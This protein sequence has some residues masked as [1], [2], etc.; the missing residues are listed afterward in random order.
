[1][2]GVMF[3]RNAVG[4]RNSH[5][6]SVSSVNEDTRQGS[7]HM[8]AQPTD[9]PVRGLTTAVVY[10]LA[11]RISPHTHPDPAAWSLGAAG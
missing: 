7:T 11:A 3:L 2:F 9:P 5:G 8:G 10:G 4:I 6:Y 1:M